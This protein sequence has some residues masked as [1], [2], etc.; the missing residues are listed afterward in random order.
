[1]IE[2][3]TSMGGNFPLKSMNC[4]IGNEG[5]SNPA[6]RGRAGDDDTA[7]ALDDHWDIPHELNHVAEALLGIKQDRLA[8]QFLAF[9]LRHGEVGGRRGVA[10]VFSPFIFSETLFEFAL[11]KK[12]QAAR[13]QCASA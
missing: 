8:V 1:M 10:D 13:F 6:Q 11:P 7:A 9:P 12:D 3:W 5:S 4:A 2:H